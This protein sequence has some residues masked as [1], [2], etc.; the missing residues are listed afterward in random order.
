MRGVRESSAKAKQGTQWEVQTQ[1]LLCAVE[2]EMFLLSLKKLRFSALS[3]S[4]RRSSTM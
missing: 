4:T 3:D 1:D 2:T